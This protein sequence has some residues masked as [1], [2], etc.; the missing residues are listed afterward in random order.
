MSGN[1]RSRPRRFKGSSVR[2]RRGRPG[3]EVLEQRLMLT[4]DVWTGGGD[5]KTWQDANNWSMKVVPGS[6]DD[7]TINVT[8]NLTIGYNGTSSIQSIVDNAG[9]AITGGSLTV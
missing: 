5:G 9:I 3:L 1:R 7:V 6:P 2:G 4:Q 8:N